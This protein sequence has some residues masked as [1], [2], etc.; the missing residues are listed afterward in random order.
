MPFSHTAPRIEFTELEDEIQCL[1]DQD[2][3]DLERD[4]YGKY[5]HEIMETETLRLSSLVALRMELDS[6]D[7]T[8]T[9]ADKIEI[10]QRAQQTCPMY[11]TSES[12]LLPFLRAEHFQVQKA[13][14]RII[15]Y[16]KEKYNLF[17]EALTFGPITYHGG[18]Q[19]END[20]NVIINGGF[21]LLPHDTHGRIVLHRDRIACQVKRYGRDSV[22]RVSLHSWIPLFRKMIPFCNVL[23]THQ[24]TFFTSP[25]TSMNDDVLIDS[26]DDSLHQLRAFLYLVHVAIA[27]DDAA[28]RK[29][30][31]IL[32]ASRHA[33]QLD[34][35]DRLYMKRFFQLISC[36]PIRVVSYHIVGAFISSNFS[37]MVMPSVHWL[38]GYHM[39]LRHRVHNGSSNQ[40]LQTS[41]AVY[42]ITKLPT[43]LGGHVDF[44]GT[45]W[46]QERR[47]IE[48][49]E[50][51]EKK[52][53]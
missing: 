53:G 44:D 4:L 42:G 41:L 1:S 45:E 10:Y 36:L 35:H 15:S 8:A 24:S 31:V 40:E 30:M 50:I 9:T 14:S 12:F 21:T 28:Q 16:W 46:L 26:I 39:S 48:E 43:F 20:W 34:D 51:L 37:A 11:A 7:I 33:F 47:R 49:K 32:S 29:G 13:A 6:F 2:R 19:Q 23:V 52:Q 18:L 3:K 5:D 38:M 27:K 17:G 25:P 22:V